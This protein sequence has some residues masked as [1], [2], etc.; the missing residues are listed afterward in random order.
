[1]DTKPI[2]VEFMNGDY[3]KAYDLITG[4]KIKIV[5]K[6]VADVEPHHATIHFDN[7]ADRDKAIQL[8]EGAGIQWYPPAPF[9]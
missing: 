3:S 6:T 5:Y 1:M 8:L 2:R 9:F 7:A 4:A